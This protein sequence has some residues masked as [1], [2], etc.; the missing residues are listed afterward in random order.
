MF[1]RGPTGLPADPPLAAHGVQVSSFN[2]SFYFILNL[3]V[4][5]SKEL[6]SHFLNLPPALQPQVLISSP[7]YRCI[8]TTA[9]IA[10]A[11][12]LP[13]I[14]DEGISEWHGRVSNG[15]ENPVAAD[16]D[17]LA[18]M[19]PQIDANQSRNY[20]VLVPNSGETMKELFARISLALEKIISRYSEST[21]IL[22]CLHAA[23]NIMCGRALTGD[24]EL[25]VHTGT[26]SIG[27]YVRISDSMSLGNWKCIRNGDC[28]H[29]EEG[30]ERDWEFGGDEPGADG[31][32]QR[33][34]KL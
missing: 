25:K 27:E 10:D 18:S 19:F 1:R 22:I 14:L 15:G 31:N 12:G 28:S 32:I 9:P 26:A 5:Q 21:S 11:L 23:V 7:Y 6:A 13:I 20:T 3:I 17:T 30:E 2:N 34:T 29:L 4:K 16:V 33:A 24:H 8:Q